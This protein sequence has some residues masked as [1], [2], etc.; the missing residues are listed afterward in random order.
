MKE[1]RKRYWVWVESGSSLDRLLE[2]LGPDGRNQWLVAILEAG[3]APGG[4]RDLITR[5]DHLSVAPA[6]A[7]TD[8]S[9]A[10]PEHLRPQLTPEA[11]ANAKAALGVFGDDD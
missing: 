2:A 6:P 8:T 10:A 7:V 5:L 9:P 11:Q 4:L 3:L 1:K